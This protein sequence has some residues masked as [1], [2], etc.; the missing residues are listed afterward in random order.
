ML[1]SVCL[2][3][4]VGF[5][6]AAQAADDRATVTF[7]LPG[8]TYSSTNNESKPDGGDAVKQKG[9]DMVTGDLGDSYV[10]FTFGNCA[11]YFYPYNNLKVVSFGYMVTDMVEVGIDLGLNS[12]KVDKPKTES[13]DNTFGVYAFAYPKLGNL[14]S[15]AG[16]TIDQGTETGKKTEVDATGKETEVKT[17]VAKMETKLAANVIVPIR[18][19][20]QYVGGLFYKMSSENDKEAKIKNSTSGFGVNLLTMRATLD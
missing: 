1:R 10:Q 18:K 2:F 7:N 15:E 13:T 6:G 19:N 9:T 12:S 4:L 11:M 5:A 17:N 3:G 8:L 14:D 16:L 20:L